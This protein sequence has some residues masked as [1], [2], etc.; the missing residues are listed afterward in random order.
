MSSL[1]LPAS[2]SNYANA[3]LL[4][5][6][7]ALEYGQLPLEALEAIADG[8]ARVDRIVPLAEGADPAAARSLRLIAT[9]AYDVWLI[10]WP[11]GSGIGWH[12]H[13][14]S[15][16]VTRVVSG[17]L[18]ETIPDGSSVTLRPGIF[19]TLA[20]R[21]SHDLHNPYPAPA[22]T[23][24]VYSPPLADMTFSDRQPLSE[25]T[26]NRHKSVPPVRAEASSLT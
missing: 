9:A 20:S 3:R 25:R 23:V 10:T 7:A 24:H 14:P 8:L 18:V 16:S 22:T 12:D 6:S 15:D 11:P 4:H 17:A 21:E 13:G 19:A 5:P 2:E 1:P 26:R